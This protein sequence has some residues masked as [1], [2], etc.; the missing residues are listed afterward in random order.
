[1]LDDFIAALLS[2]SPKDIPLRIMIA[3]RK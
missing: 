3:V 1:V 2:S